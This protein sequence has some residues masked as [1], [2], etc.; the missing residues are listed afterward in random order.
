MAMIVRRSQHARHSLGLALLPALALLQ[1][2]AAPPAGAQVTF[3]QTNLV[4]DIPGL[5]A[6]T[7]PNLKNPWG[8]SFAPTSP[9]WV[10][11][12]VT[13]KATLY[14]GS[15]TPQ[16][17][18]VTIP[19]GNPTGQLFNS[20]ASDFVLPVGGKSLFLFASLNGTIS[21]WNGG[22]GTTAQT[23]ATHAGSVYTGLTL[24]NPGTGNLLYAADA[25][26]GHIDVYNSTFSLTTLS[27]SF[28]DPGV[29]AGF[30][31]YNVRD[32]NGTVYVTYEI[33]NQPGGVLDA[34]DENGNFLRRLA[35]NG[36][37]GVLSEPWGLVLAPSTFGPFGNDLLV[38]NK[39]DGH[40]SAFD[41][42]TGQFL[43]QLDALGG[44]PIA[45][46]G[47]WGLTFGNGGA[48]GDPN[49]LFFS[50]GINNE[51]NGLFGTIRAVPEPGPIALL[52]GLVVSGTLFAA[53]RLRRRK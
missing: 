2:T 49:T 46:T 52:S 3:Q 43:G 37:G 31:P 44:S 12:Q 18:I 35:A 4:S 39:G 13:G 14:N 36:A 5:A 50:A 20:T 6:H 26:T 10:S 32:I 34:F 23:V 21:G 28:T 48:G 22:S 7:D 41:P 47:L 24:G 1:L 27:G 19:G 45:N 29:P 15:G 38:G 53:R 16:S 8:V 25:A 30:K 33:R 11:D 40:I 51:T 9:I 42:T 17:L